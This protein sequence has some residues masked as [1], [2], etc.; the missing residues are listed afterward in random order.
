MLK[1][2]V[3]ATDLQDLQPEGTGKLSDEKLQEVTGGT[4]TFGHA[5]PNCGSNNYRIFG[6]GLLLCLD[7]RYSEGPA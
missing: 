4:W 5:C 7:C 2:N 6:K 3:T 1:E